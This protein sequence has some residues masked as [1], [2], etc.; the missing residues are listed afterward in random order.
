[1]HNSGSGSSYEEY[2]RWE[3]SGADE[4]GRTG[5][6][7]EKR[8]AGPSIDYKYE[9]HK[10]QHFDRHSN[11]LI[12]VTLENLYKRTGLH[13]HKVDE[14]EITRKSIERKAPKKKDKPANPVG[15]DGTSAK[16]DEDKAKNNQAP[17]A[18]NDNNNNNSKQVGSGCDRFMSNDT[19]PRLSGHRRT[20]MVGSM[21][22]RLA[23]TSAEPELANTTISK[24]RGRRRGPSVIPPRLVLR[25]EEQLIAARWR[26]IKQSQRQQQQQ[27]TLTDTNGPM[28]LWYEINKDR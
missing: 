9:Y 8:Q 25:V 6:E 15:G 13:G 26:D 5:F 23:R 11:D 24:R 12:D 4:A 27:A 21:E 19:H 20:M 16:S 28:V 2:E 3:S 22:P 18:K 14:M 1:M 7:F 17:Q 10:S